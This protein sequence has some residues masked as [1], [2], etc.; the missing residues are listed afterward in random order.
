MTKFKLQCDTISKRAPPSPTTTT[1]KLPL[2]LG[3]LGSK[4]GFK[5]TTTVFVFYIF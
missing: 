2:L 5:L 4:N 1:T 3:L